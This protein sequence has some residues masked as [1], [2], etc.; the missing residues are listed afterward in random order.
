VCGEK[1]KD[2]QSD[3]KNAYVKIEW[4]GACTAKDNSGPRAADGKIIFEEDNM[5]K[6]FTKEIALAKDQKI[7]EITFNAINFFKDDKCEDKVVENAQ[8][9][10]TGT[11][12]K[13]QELVEDTGFVYLECNKE[14]ELIGKK[15]NVDKFKNLVGPLLEFTLNNDKSKCKKFDDKW[16]QVQWTG[17]CVTGKEKRTV[18]PNV[19]DNE[20]DDDN[21]R[22]KVML[23][24]DA[25]KALKEMIDEEAITEFEIKFFEEDKCKTDEKDQLFESIGEVKKFKLQVLQKKDNIVYYAVC[26]GEN[27]LDLTTVTGTKGDDANVIT[28][29]TTYE[30]FRNGNS[31]QAKSNSDNECQPIIVETTK[32]GTSETKKRFMKT[33]W[34]GSCTKFSNSKRRETDGEKNL[35]SQIDMTNR[36]AGLKKYEEFENLLKVAEELEMKVKEDKPKTDSTSPGMGGGAIAAIV[37]GS[38]VGVALIA[39]L[40]WYLCYKKD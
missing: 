8:K 28:T 17:A 24:A 26:K 35:F 22:V 21:K 27:K 9:P 33:K 31:D 39:G 23:L 29:T 37:I 32:S 34:N 12:Y 40:V 30:D 14:K 5:V 4:S 3:E 10:L 1:N 2:T 18:D 16:V 20:D 25:D 7:R 11:S 15:L 13:L 38:L 19:T 36:V 6:I